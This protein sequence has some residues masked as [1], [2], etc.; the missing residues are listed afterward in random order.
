MV[1]MVTAMSAIAQIKVTGNVTDSKG[2]PIIG[3]SVVV[4]DSKQGTITDVNGEFSLNANSNST[5]F[6]SYIGY[7]KQEIAVAGKTKINA[8]LQEDSELL[9]KVVEMTSTSTVK[10]KVVASITNIDMKQ[11]EQMGSYKD[12]GNALQGRV[13]GSAANGI[14]V[15]T[16]KKGR[17]GKMRIGYTFDATS[18]RDKYNSMEFAEMQNSIYDYMGSAK[19]YSDEVLALI[20]SGTSADYPNTDWWN[21]LIK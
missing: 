7:Q 6:I 4:K 5:L 14:I 10:R 17:E 3:A 15:V 19:P 20:K 2:E 1:M 18:M 21:K 8:V 12:L 16:T 11:I 9:D 13:P